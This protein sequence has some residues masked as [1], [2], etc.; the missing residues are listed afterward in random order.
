M[1]KRFKRI[2]M[3]LVSSQFDYVL[4][5]FLKFSGLSYPFDIPNNKSNGDNGSNITCSNKCDCL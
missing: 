4:R 5:M 1:Q 3:F 2:K